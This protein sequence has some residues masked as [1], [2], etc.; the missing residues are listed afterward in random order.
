VQST[1]P[2]I[3]FI[4]NR[5][6]TDARAQFLVQHDGG[7]IFFTAE[8][9]VFALPNAVPSPTGKERKPSKRPGAALDNGQKTFSVVRQRFIQAQNS[10]ALQGSSL[11]PGTVNYLKGN[12]PGGWQT[13]VPTYGGLSYRQLYPGIDLAYTGTDGKLKSTFYVSPGADPAAIR[14]RYTGITSIATDT[15]GNLVV[16]VPPRGPGATQALTITE[17]APVAWQDINGA[18]VPVAVQFSVS[19][20][21]TVGFSLGSYNPAYPLA[22]DPVLTYST[23]LGGSLRDIAQSVTAD[24]LGNAYVTGVTWSPNFPATNAVQLVSS[25]DAFV[26]KLSPDGS[27]FV[28]STYIGGTGGNRG[29]DIAVDATGNAYVTG[30][31]WSTDFPTTPNPIQNTGDPDGNAFVTKINPA[32]TALVYSTYLGGTT[33]VYD[34]EDIGTGIALDSDGAAYI[35]GITYATDF[36][37]ENAYDGSLASAGSG[38]AFVA[39]LNAT[40]TQLVYSTYY[41]G[42][43]GEYW[44][45]Y[46]Y[47]SIAVDQAGSAYITGVT[48]STDIPLVNAYQS[49]TVGSSAFVAKFSVDGTALAYSTYLGGGNEDG[50]FGVAVDSLGQANIVGWTNSAYFL[51]SGGLQTALRGNGDMFL[52]VLSASGSSLVAGT[53]LGGSSDDI[54]TG[55]A[56]DEAGYVYLSGE[57][58]SSNFPTQDPLQSFTAVPGN[59]G[60]GV[61]VKLSPKGEELLFSTYWGGASSDDVHAIATDNANSIFIAGET[62]SS[63]FPT[64]QAIDASFGGYSEGF[65]ARFSVPLD[66]QSMRTATDPNSCGCNRAPPAPVSPHPSTPFPVN[67]RTGNF[68]TQAVDLSVV[69]PGPALVWQRTYASQATV[70]ITGPLGYGW[71]HSYAARLVTP[72]MSGGEAGYAIILSPGANQLRFHSVGNGRYQS[73]AGIYSTLVSGSG[74][75]TETLRDQQQRIFDAATG[76]LI[77]MRD[78]QGRVLTLAYTG[79]PARLSSITDATNPARSLTITYTAAGQIDTVSDGDRLV[80]YNYSGQ[81]DLT[82]VTD[83]MGR[84]TTYTYVGHLLT[85]IFDALG[86]PVERIGYAGALAASKVMTQTLEDGRQVAFQYLANTTIVTTTGVDGSEEV[87]EYDFTSNEALAGIWV[88]GE[89]QLASMFDTS[90][91]PAL[92]RDANGNATRTTA[93]RDGLPL[94]IT[95]ALGAETEIN[96]NAQNNPTSVI[97]PLGRRSEMAYDAQQNLIRQTVGI[98]T[99]TPLG[100]TTLYTYTNAFLT[101]QQDPSGVIRRYDRNA[102]G[103]V[104]TATVGYGTSDALITTYGYDALGRVVTTTTGVGT[105]LARA[106]VTVYNDDNTVAQ[107][108]Q[109]YVN[110]VFDPA[111]PDEDLITAYGYDR[112]GRQVWAKDPLGHYAATHYNADGRVDWTVQNLTPFQLSSDDQPIFQSFDRTRPDQNVATQYA[113]DGLGRTTLVTETGILDGA[114]DPTTRTFSGATT[115][116]TRTEYDAQSRPITVTLNYQPGALPGPDVNVQTLTQYDPAGNVIGQRDALGRWTVTDYDALNR[117]ITVTLNYENGNP[118]TVEAGNTSWATITDTDL[119]QVTAYTTDGQVASTI[120][121]YI[122]GVYSASEPDRDRKTVYVYDALG[123]QTQLIRNYVDGNPA[124]GSSDTDLVTRTVYDA[125]GRVQATTDPLGQYTSQVYDALGRVER[126]IQNCRDSGGTP[127]ATGCAAFNPSRPDRNVP[128]SIDYDVLGRSFQ[129]TDA[130]NHVTR[131]SYDRLGRVVS[132]TRNY[133]SGGAVDSDTNVTSS[134]TYDALGRVVVNTDPLGVETS[135][136]YDGLGRAVTATDGESRV[137]RMGYDGAGGVRWSETPDGRFT[138]TLVDGLG[139][140]TTTI[141]NYQDGLIIRGI[142]PADQDLIS[143]TVY[144]V[145]GRVVAT[146]DAEGYETR[147]TYDLRD[148]LRTVTENVTDSTCAVAPCNVTTSYA[149]DR[150]GNRLS[151][152]DANNHTRTFAYDAADRQVASTDA[153]NQTTGY[154]YDR[155]GRLTF[156]DDPRGPT[157]DVTYSYDEL[158]RPTG[159]SATELDGPVSMGYNALGWRTS[160]SDG[161]GT[162][163]FAHDELGRVTGVTAPATG[164]VGYGYNAIGQRTQ[165]V[166]PDSSAISY[167]YWADGQLKDVLQGATVLASY[168]YDPAGRLQGLSR[169]NGANTSYG[170][171]GADRL[172]DL[173]TA[174][175]GQTLSEFTYEVDRRGLRRVVTEMLRDPVAPPASTS[176][177]AATATATPTETATAAA[178]ATPTATDTATPASTAATN[179]TPAPTD[180]P[181]PADTATP[182]P[183][184]TSTG[185]TGGEAATS[186]GD[187]SGIFFNAAFVVSSRSELATGNFAPVAQGGTCPDSY[188]PNNTVAAAKPI[189]VSETQSHAFCVAGDVDWLSFS[190]AAGTIY[191]FRTL[192]LA[193]GVDTYLSLYGTNGVT[194][195]AASDDDGGGLSSLI[196]YTIPQAGT[197]YLKVR[198]Y[199]SNAGGD[200][201]TYQIQVTSLGTA[202]P[203]PTQ[204]ACPDAYEPNDSVSQAR[205]MTLGQTQTHYICVPGD[206][207]W[208][209][210]AAAAGTRYRI[211]TLDLAAGV[212]TYIYLYDINGTAVIGSDDDSGPGS[213]SLLDYTVGQAGTY[214]VR[215]RDYSSGTGGPTLSYGLRISVLTAPTATATATTSPTATASPT[216]TT[217]PTATATR[218]ATA[219]PT[220]TRTATATATAVATMTPT[221]TPTTEPG[222][223]R[224]TITYNYDGLARLTGAQYSSGEQYGYGYDLAG[225]RT[226]VTTNGSTTTTVY[227]A[228]NQVVD[229]SYDAAGNLLSDGSSTSTYD[230]LGRMTSRSGTGYRYNGDGVLVA[231]IAAGNTTRYTQ[232]LVAALSSV[233]SDGSANYL[234]SHERLAAQAGGTTTWY[235]ADALGS[236]RQTLGNAGI[237]L[238]TASY[239]PWGTPQSSAIS[240]FGFTGE[241][242]DAAGLT[243]LRARWYTPGAGTFLSARWRTSESNDF[244][245]LS[246]HIYAYG[247][248]NPISNTD[249]SGRCVPEY[250]EIGGVRYSVPGGEP[251]CRPISETGG[252]LNWADGGQYFWDVFQGIGSPGAWAVDQLFGTNA[253]DCIWADPSIG[254]RLGITFT[255]V[256]TAGGAYKYVITPVA[257]RVAAWLAPA[258]ATATGIVSKFKPSDVEALGNFADEA[259]SIQAGRNMESFGSTWRAW[260]Q[261]AVA[262]DDVA[263]DLFVYR[264]GDRITGAMKVANGEAV[265]KVTHLEALGGGAGT[266]LLQAA[267]RESMARG[268]SGQ[269]LLNSSQQAVRFYERLGFV[270]SDPRYNEYRL[271]VEA[272]RQLLQK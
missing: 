71:Q 85:G 155:L 25:G 7:T 210:F 144:D 75:Y 264:A 83:V 255:G 269:L 180:T 40:G 183:T 209:S 216:A 218:T 30:A 156:T 72:T 262:M 107:S 197:Y 268:Y 21:R 118:L 135:A 195:L 109:N 205:P 214:Y 48:D 225:N 242:Q 34:A 167:T 187:D 127:V 254:K 105:S 58:W 116:A 138:V 234:Y 243:Y 228:A 81:G 14:W 261:A 49:S 191:R 196:E 148:A 266:S 99:A 188:E 240:P 98:T 249:P 211:E 32:G 70:D 162:T 89:P 182:T 101:E 113:Y 229:W 171:D 260:G 57:T 184:D 97:D 87:Q 104:I 19:S 253:W 9:I 42:N 68:W 13:N 120:D 192:N 137:R 201:L 236:V 93:T 166:Y 199:S 219:T 110:G 140:A 252:G 164:S 124:T 251:G 45:L 17:Q 230:A 176:T 257:Q 185:A 217:P 175:N 235:A 66:P 100:F 132:T 52:A 149:Y 126:T 246:H 150:A 8:D 69:S 54:G 174:R 63:N 39:K 1:A 224:R 20:G 154:T 56:L 102:A 121:N 128:V 46:L 27:Q 24:R 103:Q 92:V 15:N 115:R 207:D 157:Y 11:L 10:V 233:L 51:P 111:A 28:Y 37:L 170:Y 208:V 186:A 5:G 241:L 90:F 31:T 59:N 50:A 123:R 84:P 61:V 43:E 130:L 73:P 267:V 161:T 125:L 245:P 221:V 222:T 38:D 35:T 119:I 44:Y 193:S 129:S 220:A 258:A 2:G 158:D 153:L 159:M 152:T 91:S 94:T 247:L 223:S 41:G 133:V 65:V 165:L 248:N 250:I 244:L 168:S 181:A 80:D 33:S 213:A 18:R 55:I 178:T 169:A 86:R 12:D 206:Q 238:A 16:T 265:L 29:Y 227:N 112:L 74:V 147:F 270:L 96:Y 237:P 189:A 139:R 145:A 200:S 177:V 117:P 272:A 62:A 95:D 26:T 4:R 202:S 190:A 271:S 141:Q 259:P 47:P 239:D 163:S 203:T 173:A 23:F 194:E 122:D 136:T 114:F 77:Q 179:D 142:E 3:P 60:D 53:Y 36:P 263:D 204:A 215:A 67:T 108:I 64:A 160:M 22:I 172:R 76:R 212:D 226:S 131:Q 256:A 134:Q 82:S 6:Q 88:N 151:I 78:A 232:D 143:R 79:T 198:H 106:D 146:I 231:Q